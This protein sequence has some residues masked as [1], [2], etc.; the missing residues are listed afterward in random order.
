MKTYLLWAGLIT[1]CSLYFI[2]KEATFLVFF[3]PWQKDPQNPMFVSLECLYCLHRFFPGPFGSPRRHPLISPQNV[4]ILIWVS[5]I[6]IAIMIAS[7]ALVLFGASICFVTPVVAR[8]DLCL[9]PTSI[10]GAGLTA[11]LASALLRRGLIESRIWFSSQFFPIPFKNS[12]CA[13]VNRKYEGWFR[14]T[15]ASGSLHKWLLWFPCGFW[16]LFVAFPLYLVTH[17]ALVYWLILGESSDWIAAGAAYTHV[18]E[19]RTMV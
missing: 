14:C 15:A 4:R 9:G 1:C 3:V 19:V 7:S 12:S 6:L 11:G 10:G 16:F 17:L 8:I 13:S 5:R 18:K 2:S